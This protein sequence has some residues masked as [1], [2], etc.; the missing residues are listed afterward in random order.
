MIRVNYQKLAEQI[1]AIPDWRFQHADDIAKKVGVTTRSLQRY[2][3]Q[4]RRSGLLPA[5]SR[6]KSDT[7][8][9]YLK[10]KQYLAT[11]PGQLNLTLMVEA[12]IG[13][14]CSGS[15]MDTYRNAIVLAKAEGL[16]LGYDRIEDVK[17]IRVKPAGGVKWRTD[18]QLRFIDWEQVDPDHLTGFVNLC[19][20]T[21]GRHAA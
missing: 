12:I 18:G 6:M 20:M 8:K 2:M 5:P 1:Q 10:L 15:N 13:G 4:M 9:S 11:H 3:F 16:P 14:Y 17:P 21:G 19:R 7:Y